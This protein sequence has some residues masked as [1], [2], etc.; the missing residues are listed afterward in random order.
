M[1]CYVFLSVEFL[2]TQFPCDI[3]TYVITI[4]VAQPVK[5]LTLKLIC[6]KIS[7]CGPPIWSP[8]ADAWETESDW[9]VTYRLKLQ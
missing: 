6:S 4:T 8:V 2:S 9:W 7:T 1:H 5:H 3:Y